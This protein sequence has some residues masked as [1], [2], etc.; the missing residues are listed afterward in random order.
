MGKDSDNITKM[1]L[2]THT[3]VKYV[4]SCMRCSHSGP[5]SR[6]IVR[7]HKWLIPFVVI[8]CVLFIGDILNS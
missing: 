2:K 7:A 6:E 5:D 8:Q 4:Q 3:A 1:Y